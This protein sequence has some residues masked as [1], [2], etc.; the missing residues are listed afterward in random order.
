M[1]EHLRLEGTGPVATITLARAAKLNAR[2]SA[3][4]A[5]LVAVGRPWSAPGPDLVSIGNGIC[6]AR[7]EA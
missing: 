6:L 2:T 7:Q 3:M 4:L 1:T 5:R